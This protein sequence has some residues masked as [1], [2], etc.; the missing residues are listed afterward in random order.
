MSIANEY[1]KIIFINLK[2]N[3]GLTK[4]K[5]GYYVWHSKIIDVFKDYNIAVEYIKYLDN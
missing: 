2:G 1:K 3:L 5:D 4:E